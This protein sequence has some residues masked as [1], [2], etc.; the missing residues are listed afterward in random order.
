VRENSGFRGESL[1]R[2]PRLKPPE[3][4][5]RSIQPPKGGRS[6]RITDDRDA[7]TSSHADPKARG[8]FAGFTAR[9]NSCPFASCYFLRL[10]RQAMKSC[11]VSSCRF[12]QPLHR[13]SPLACRPGRG[14]CLTKLFRAV[15][16]TDFDGLASDPDLDGFAFE[17]AVARR[18]CFLSHIV[19]LSR[20][21]RPRAR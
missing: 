5:V 1:T 15:F 20:T 16:A 9:V 7:G 18:T 10:F 17:L 4:F 11:H 12:L 21:S 14:S 6:L 2:G 13:A 3:S 8:H 19:L